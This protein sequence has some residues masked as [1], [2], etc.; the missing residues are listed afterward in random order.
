MAVAQDR[1]SI[2]DAHKL[3]NAMRNDQNRRTCGPQLLNGSVQAQSGIE[4][5]RRRRLVENKNA[6]AAKKSSC[7]DDPLF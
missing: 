4:I 1:G 7:D 3:R 2:G 5:K 6:R